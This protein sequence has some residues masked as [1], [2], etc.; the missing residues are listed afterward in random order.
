MVELH[1]I[2]LYIYVIVKADK[3]R[4]QEYTS[5]TVKSIKLSVQYNKI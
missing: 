2:K 4:K 1:E 5:N 3:I